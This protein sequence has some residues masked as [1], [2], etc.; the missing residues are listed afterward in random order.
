MFNFNNFFIT[1]NYLS[2]LVMFIC[3]VVLIKQ[4]A[5]EM[6]KV[7]MVVAFSLTISTLGYLFL[8]EAK[9]LETLILAQKLKYIF[10]TF[11]M[12]YMLMFIFRYCNYNIPKIIRMIFPT[13]NIVIASV[14]LTLDY[15]Q[16]FYKSYW[17]VNEGG[18]ISLEKEY[19]IFHTITVALFGLYMAA[20]LV[21]AIVYSVNNIKHR[22]N[23]VW[24]MLFAVGL[25][26]FS[27]IANKV[28]DLRHD[29]QPIA[30]AFF[31]VLVLTMIYK[32]K[33]YDVD[34]IAANYSLKSFDEAIIV[35]DKNMLFKG[36]ND[37]AKELF[38][39]LKTLDIDQ[40]IL[41]VSKVLD[42]IIT[43]EFEDYRY[44]DQI[45]GVSISP[46]NSD[47]GTTI[48]KV[49]RFKNVTVERNYTEL[50]KGQKKDLES[51]VKILSNI[52][53]KD[54][55]T[56]CNNR[57]YYEEVV[58]EI[59]SKASVKNVT[60]WEMDINGLKETND[61]IG[62]NA[63]D[64]IIKATAKILEE[65][66]NSYGKVFRTGGDEFFVII[67]NGNVD[68]K[69]LANKLDKITKE[70]HGVLVKSL[71]ISY[72]YVNG[73]DNL[74]KSIDEIMIMADK[75]MYEAKHRYY[76]IAGNDRRHYND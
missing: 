73:N 72:G 47:D 37:F 55:L 29:I 21:L 18:L 35:L 71:S 68:N 67:Q 51:Q 16:L 13:L 62:H 17:L 6:Q 70:W 27:Y 15:H 41:N 76:Q 12:Y 38:S 10:I 45:Y 74:D 50:L 54:E 44:N 4:P 5:S 19:G 48:G 53:Y 75:Q 14:I 31:T 58:A 32:N 43:G 52:S 20:A 46:V 9:T 40:S 63:G 8:A 24:R 23:Y 1:L 57:R 59:R 36:C 49:V 30:F 65:V 28:F 66:F 22:R 7:A 64:E 34:N 2:L 26:C 56:N 11:G 60:V 69:K 33:L 42:S 25:P 39:E 61:S 3:L